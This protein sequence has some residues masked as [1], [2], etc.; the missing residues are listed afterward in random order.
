MGFRKVGSGTGHDKC[1]SQF[2]F[3]SNQAEE[4]EHISQNLATVQAKKI[5]LED[6]K[7]CLDTD[8]YSDETD[9]VVGH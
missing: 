6:P 4:C 3:D 8:I 7:L 2:H 9:F 5:K 1:G